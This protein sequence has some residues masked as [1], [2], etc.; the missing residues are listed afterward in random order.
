MHPILIKIGPISLYSYGFMLALGVVCAFW[1]T[2]IQAKKQNLP[3][4]KLIDMGFYTVI[5][6]LVGAKLILF[7]GNFSY[8]IKNPKDLFSLAR[9]GGVFQGG[10]AFGII[11]ALWYFRKHKLP[12]WK[13]A[14]IIGPAL[15]LGHGFG[16][17]GCF[18]AGCCYGRSCTV[19]W[20]VTFKS[21]Q[22]HNI[23][24]IPINTLLHATQL[25]ESILNFLNFFV[26]FFILRR[27]KFEGQVFSFYVINYSVL[28]F[29]VEYYRGDHPD[30][31]FLIKH[32]S[33]Y[34]SLSWPQFFCLVGIAAGVFLLF[35]MRRR[36]K[37]RQEG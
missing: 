18:L 9:S 8:Y 35:F 22:A 20:G 4:T 14:D 34:L 24:G 36:Q 1:F 27:K 16:R 7:I 30:R 23:T 6:A 11:F 5:I 26:L 32:S 15:A 37:K 13:I 17:I 28:R 33:P 12:T 25:Y 3:A 31:V 29:F 10:L 21:V 2:Y 19:P